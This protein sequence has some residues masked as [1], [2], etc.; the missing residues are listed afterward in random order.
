[1]TAQIP[2]E[3]KVTL[4][5]AIGYARQALNGIT[6][7][8]PNAPGQ[9]LNGPGD[10]ASPRALHPAFYGCF[11]WHSAVHSHWLLVK[12]LR[13]FP[14]LPEA[15]TIRAALNTNLTADN[16]LTE[17]AYFDQPNHQTFERMYGWAWV[18]KLDL[19]LAHWNDLDGQSWWQNLQPLTNTISRLFLKFLPKLTYSIRVGTHS[20][21]AFSLI[22]ALEF[23]RYTNN[24]EL[25]DLLVSR[26]LA[27]FGQDKAYPANWEPHGGDFLSPALIEADLMSQVLSPTDFERWFEDFLPNIAN[28]QP[29]VLLNPVIISDISDPSL[30]HLNGLHLS[31]AWSMLQIAHSLPAQNAAQGVLLESAVRHA[32]AGLP[33]VITEDYMGGHWMASFALY[34]QTRNAK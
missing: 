23:A 8:Y 33:Q 32:Q 30:G 1:M 14:A 26:G 7:E 4:E 28:G 16:L 21:T 27:Y 5:Q 17:A 20:N 19:E 31:R 18:L 2:F 29:E 9:I 11:D 25:E 3:L 34:L 15:A 12:V 22:F 10:I 6:R 13:M 24:K